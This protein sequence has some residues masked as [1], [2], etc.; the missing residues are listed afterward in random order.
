MAV[1]K[2][3]FILKSDRS[4]AKKD[5]VNHD[6]NNAFKTLFFVCL[7]KWQKLF[8]FNSDIYTISP[9]LNTTSEQVLQH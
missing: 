5:E 9:K 1:Q 2:K 3:L 4:T 6:L 8:C 7:K